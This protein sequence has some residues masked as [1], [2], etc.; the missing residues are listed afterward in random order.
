M[1]MLE[2]LWS[3]DIGLKQTEMEGAGVV[4]FENQRVLGGSSNYFYTGSYKV[5]DGVVQGEVEVRFYGRKKS[6]FFEF[7]TK[8]R[9]RFSGKVRKFMTLQNYVVE[10]PK[11]EIIVRLNKR[12]ELS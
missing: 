7:L 8:F 11:K 1:K 10:D 3:V 12:A 4:V 5:K 6:P 2:G 9:V